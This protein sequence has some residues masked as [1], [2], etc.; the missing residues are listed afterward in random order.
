[1]TSLKNKVAL[2]SWSALGLGKAIEIRYGSLGASVVVNYSTD[3]KH[4]QETVEVI[5]RAGSA[6]IAVQAD[7]SKVYDID[8]LF[9]AA[10]DKFGS[11]DVVVLNDL[12]YWSAEIP[13]KIIAKAGP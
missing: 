11:L 10:L 9:V 7:I 13:G 8:R 6:A 2:V 1:M 12:S 4:A 3:E 5:K